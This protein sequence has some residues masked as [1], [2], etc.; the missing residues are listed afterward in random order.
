MK[1]S[2]AVDSQQMLVAVPVMI[3]VSMPPLAA[4]FR[5]HERIREFLSGGPLS[6]EFRWRH[7]PT[8]VNGQA[9]LGTYSW[10]EQEACFLPFCFDVFTFEGERI[11]EVTSFITRST[12]SRDPEYYARFPDQA[13]DPV[14]LADFERFGLPGRLD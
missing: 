1:A 12:G 13:I 7:L 10:V 8:R 6:G 11:K 3:T 4:W 9:A 2:R 5:G 14:K